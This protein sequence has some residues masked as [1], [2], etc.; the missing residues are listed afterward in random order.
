MLEVTDSRAGTADSPFFHDPSKGGSGEG[1]VNKTL[2]WAAPPGAAE[3]VPPHTAKA[4]R[5]GPAASCR[6]ALA[7][8]APLPTWPGAPPLRL[9]C[10][11]HQPRQGQG[12]VLQPGGGGARRGAA[13]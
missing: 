11:Q 2:R 1:S 5:R 3:R 4:P 8:A 13:P 10:P 9:L 12:L 7:R 6:A